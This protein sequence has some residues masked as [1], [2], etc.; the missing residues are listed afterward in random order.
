LPAQTSNFNTVGFNH[1]TYMWTCICIT[2]VSTIYTNIS[3]DSASV[4]LET[5]IGYHWDL[6]S[7]PVH[8]SRLFSILCGFSFISL[9][10]MPCDQCYPCLWIVHSWLP[11]QFSLMFICL[12]FIILNTNIIVS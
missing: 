2:L 1:Q 9:H 10:S 6:G 7:P 12:I 8:V 11:F 3:S 5:G 4:L